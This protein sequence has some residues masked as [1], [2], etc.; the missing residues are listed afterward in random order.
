MSITDDSSILSSLADLDEFTLRL[1]SYPDPS[2]RSGVMWKR[3]RGKKFSFIRPWAKRLFVLDCKG[4][5]IE[6]KAPHD[7]DEP[8]KRGQ[9]IL[10]GGAAVKPLSSS[11]SKFPKGATFGFEI[12]T[13][14]GALELALDDEE[15]MKSWMRAIQNTIQQ[16]MIAEAK[17]Q[18]QIYDDHVKRRMEQAEARDKRKEEE[19]EA[20]LNQ[21]IV[22]STQKKVLEKQQSSIPSVGEAQGPSRESIEAEE[23]LFGAMQGKVEA[24]VPSLQHSASYKAGNKTTVLEVDISGVHNDVSKKQAD[25]LK[26][27][28]AAERKRAEMIR[29]HQQMK[30]REKKANELRRRHQVRQNFKSAVRRAVIQHKFITQMETQAKAT[31]IQR[32]GYDNTAPTKYDQRKILFEQGEGSEMGNKI[33]QMLAKKKLEKQLQAKISIPPPPRVIESFRSSEGSAPPP[34][35]PPQDTSAPSSPRPPSAPCP[36]PPKDV[37][38]SLFVSVPDGSDEYER[39]S[40]VSS[41]SSNAPPPPPQWMRKSSGL[42][43]PLP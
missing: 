27:N 15:D 16:D 11:N 2:D 10:D 32:R 3:G 43:P 30:D 40:S 6:Y 35:P 36:P 14:D 18:K 1:A 9:I 33:E 23:L 12:L 39:I 31:A 29:I 5:K 8:D 19:A 7:S 34:P 38:S 20:L 41:A 37:S 42:P 26:Q 22:N 24:N 4:K 13:A 17:I 25:Q 28:E 21:V